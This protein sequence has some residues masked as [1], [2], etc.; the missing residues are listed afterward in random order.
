MNE[1]RPL[2][3]RV[4][5]CPDEPAYGLF[6]RLALEA[7]APT[8]QRFATELGL[9]WNGIKA[10]RFVETVAV[11]NDEDPRKLAS[12]TFQNLTRGKVLFRGETYKE[13]AWQQSGRSCPACLERDRAEHGR[14]GVH[15][16]FWWDFALIAACP[17]HGLALTG[18]CPSCRAQPAEAL[19]GVCRCGALS[20]PPALVE[21]G[22]LE[23]ASYA[24]SRLRGERPSPV[25]LLNKLKAANAVEFATEIGRRNH[26]EAA[27]ATAAVMGFLTCRDKGD[28]PEGALFSLS[29]VRD[30]GTREIKR[31]IREHL[32]ALRTPP[33]HLATSA[34]AAELRTDAAFL[35]QI[36][37]VRCRAPDSAN[38]PFSLPLSDIETIRREFQDSIK[39]SAAAA[40]LGIGERHLAALLDLP[41][42]TIPLLPWAT[43]RHRFVRRSAVEAYSGI[44]R[45]PADVLGDKP[46]GTLTY[47]GLFSATRIRGVWREAALNRL[48]IG[49]HA[50]EIAPVGKL[51]RFNGLRALLFDWESLIALLRRDGPDARG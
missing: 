19:G 45:R 41:D 25:W 20:A 13:G 2:P 39:E 38:L 30:P 3:L 1:T 9:N 50:G 48:L 27:P 21:Q 31:L 35:R 32:V 14:S 11:L 36:Y 23:W 6:T 17:E 29:G 34:L 24:V 49:L 42:S 12:A 10:G 40:F 22:G 8:P 15:R 26:P 4:P 44:I 46:A 5:P 28:I 47:K 43:A 7:G 51:R 33:G 18:A 37:R 16:R